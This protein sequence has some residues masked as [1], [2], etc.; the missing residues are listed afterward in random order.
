MIGRLFRKPEPAVAPVDGPTAV[1]ALLVRVAR[2]DG[3][4]ADVEAQVV[5]DVLA[6]RYG[7]DA[8]AL[9]KAG[10]AREAELG[11]TVHLTRVIKDEIPLDERPVYL[12]DLWQ[13]VLADSRCWAWPTATLRWRGRRCRLATREGYRPLAR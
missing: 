6:R 7:A 12:Q 13:V 4:Y 2:S 11:D 3:E 9:Q 8:G 10:E 5:A 1:A